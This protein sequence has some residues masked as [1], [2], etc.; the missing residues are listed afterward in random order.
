MN[1]KDVRDEIAA[2][3]ATVSGLRVFAYNVDKLSPPAAV[4]SPPERIEFDQT[5]GRG[6]DKITLMVTVFVSR[7]DARSAEAELSAYMDGSGPKSIKA[8][9]DSSDTN[10]YDSCDTVT[11]TTAEVLYD[12]IGG[13]PVQVAEFTVEITGS[14][15]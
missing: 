8:L 10:A 6:S 1:V 9:V 14:G 11:V 5:Y 15:A 2:K 3:L 13:T 7:S 12:S 4:V